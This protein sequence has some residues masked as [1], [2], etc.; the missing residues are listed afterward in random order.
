MMRLTLAV[1]VVLCFGCGEQDSTLQP[2]TYRLMLAPEGSGLEALRLVVPESRAQATLTH[3]DV[4]DVT[5]T[6]TRLSEDD[7]E[8]GCQTNYT[9]RRLETFVVQPDPLGIGALSVPS[10]RLT[11]GC[12]EESPEAVLR[13]EVT[14]PITQLN[15]IQDK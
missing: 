12:F 3:P 6:L 2:G 10:P 14:E 7:W 4:P 8:H 9:S 1:T 13:S 5:L 11:A 15:F